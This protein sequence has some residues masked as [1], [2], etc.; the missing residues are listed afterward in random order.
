M[1]TPPRLIEPGSYYLSTRT[2]SGQR[3]WLRPDPPVTQAITYALAVT[4]ARYSTL[5]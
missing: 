2:C 5:R 3:F 1:A 4:Q